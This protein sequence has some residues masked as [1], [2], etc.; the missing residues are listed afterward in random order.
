[1]PEALEETGGRRRDGR[2]G[3]AVFA[4][5]GALAVAMTWPLA[6]APQ[7]LLHG[8]ADVRGNAWAVSWVA[9]QVVRDPLH[10]FDSN[11]YF[12]HT[13]SLA[14]AES[15]LPQGL[16]AV[17]V[18]AMGGSVALAYNL[19]LLL[20]FPLSGLGAALLARELGA[21]R[22]PALLAGLGF[23]FCAYRW[24]HIVHVQSLSTGCLPLAL[25][26]LLR[27]LR[28]GSKA[29]AAGLGLASWLQV[30][31]SGY[32]ALLLAIAVGLGLGWAVWARRREGGAGEALAPGGR[33]A[34]LAL[35]AAAL[36][37]MPVFLQHREVALR[38]G[39]RRSSAETAL[40]S[41]TATA[42][43]DPGESGHWLHSRWLH[44]RFLAREP[45]FPGSVLL[46]L[47]LYGLVALRRE[48]PAR[49]AGVL[50]LA[51]FLLAFGP[52]WR[53]FGFRLPAPFALVRLIPGGE[54]LRTP[55]RFGILGLL[56]LD[57]LAALGL[58][59][60]L[61]GSRRWAQ[62]GA[63]VTGLLAALAMV[64]AWPAGL[65]RLVRE[66]PAFPPAV[67]WLRDAQRGAVLELPWS[68]P[69]ESARYVYWS[70][71]HWQPLV[72][73]YGSFDPPGNFAV[74]LL[75]QRWPSG[76]TARQFRAAG[77][78]YVVVHTNLLGE[79]GRERWERLQDPDALPEGTA[80]LASLGADRIYGIDPA[81]P[82][83]RPNEKGPR[84]D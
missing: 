8:N 60:L 34:V 66:A 55:S 59:R 76:Y 53:A 73:G 14:Y 30:L 5:C 42:W 46:A 78:R 19:V 68:D 41:A 12:P 7:A 25:F 28:S 45:L 22:G 26:F 57:L 72:N 58:T 43:L 13:K 47:G 10:L 4:L 61:A 56:G 48:R 16:Q 54:L 65:D 79:E 9:R 39:F 11:I 21:A 69:V 63:A 50:A 82:A 15:L 27:T 84:F 29:S 80:L 75:G 83:L 36:L 77:I 3:A 49:L 40:W 2:F 64:E 81:G 35:L 74:G 17:P 67:A 33:R 24:D 71:G 23:A 38:H 51:G 37:A 20:T 18:R 44:R 70:T 1:M 31:S 6:R 62:R 52:E 32:Y